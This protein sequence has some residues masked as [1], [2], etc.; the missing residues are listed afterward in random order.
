MRYTAKEILRMLV[1]ENAD[2][3]TQLKVNKYDRKYQLWKREPLS[4]ELFNEKTFFQKFNYI[5]DNPVS[6]K[7]VA[8]AEYYKYSSAN[9]YRTGIDEFNMLTHFHGC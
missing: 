1:S 4:I 3:L 5:H 6:A 7:L 2:E 8:F 9:F